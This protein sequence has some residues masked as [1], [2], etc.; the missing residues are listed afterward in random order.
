MSSNW[1][2]TPNEILEAMP[3]MT[4]AELK[5]T[6]VLVRMTYGYH[7][8]K[9]R[10]TYEDMEQAAGI[11]RGSVYNAIERIENRGFFRRGRRSY[12]MINSTKSE[13]FEVG[14]SSE[15][16]PKDKPKSTKSELRKSTKSEPLQYNKEKEDKEII[17]IP[18][19]TDPVSKMKTAVSAISKETLWVKTESLF[20][21]A[22][23][24]L[25]GR[26]AE[27]EQ[28]AAFGEWWKVSGWHNGKPALQ[29]IL[30][31]WQDFKTG[32]SLK[33]GDDN[34]GRSPSRPIP[35]PAETRR[36]GLY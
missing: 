26:D 24:E 35:E 33:R 19:D 28:V 34:N 36:G 20:T 13:P 12:W 18:T 29:N 7:K 6:A 23:Y 15:S 30:D 25:I 3:L 16:E 21:E 8:S 31:H 32:R 4:E 11:S 22:A 17:Y 2:K 27:P 14:N 9:V 1:T 10:M 5:L